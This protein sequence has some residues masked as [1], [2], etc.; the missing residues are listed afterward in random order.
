MN[1]S[2]KP[3]VKWT[4][5]E[6]AY[7]IEHYAKDGAEKVAKHLNRTSGS[8][9]TAA[10]KLGVALLKERGTR[11]PE[12]ERDYI[13]KHADCL[14]INRIAKDLN[15]NF[16]TVKRYMQAEKLGIYAKGNFCCSPPDSCFVC[17][18]DDC[19]C[20]KNN[21]TPKEAEFLRIGMERTVGEGTVVRR[22]V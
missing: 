11:L 3:K 13:H 1:T 8:V 4:D 16:F 6:K 7:L 12:K 5:E 15:R 18:Y 9:K 22:R 2:N 17:P 20:C 21:N 10:C 14:S 19:I